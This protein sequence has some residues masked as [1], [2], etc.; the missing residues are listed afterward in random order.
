MDQITTL[1]IQLETIA[2]VV[3]CEVERI[4][5]TL[6]CLVCHSLELFKIT[7][8]D[9]AAV[10]RWLGEE[11][12]AL[13]EDGFYLS[14]PRLAAHRRGT[15]EKTAVSYSWP[16]ERMRDPDA[17]YRMYCHRNMGPMLMGLFERIKGVAWIYY[18]DVTNTA[19]QYPYIDQITAITPD[20]QWSGYHTYLSVEPGANPERGI[21]WT[22]PTMDYAGKGLILSASAPVYADDA[23]VGLWSLDVSVD[24]IIRPNL[25]A[26]SWG[27]QL[28]C[29]ADNRG[30]ALACNK[31]LGPCDATVGDEVLLPLALLHPGFASLDMEELYR[32]G[33]GNRFLSLECGNYLFLWEVVGAMDWICLSVLDKDELLSSAHERFRRAFSSL[34][35]GNG[36]AVIDLEH[37][38]PELADVGDAYNLMVHDLE[39]ARNRLLAQQ[40]DLARAKAAA[41]DAN[42]TK[43]EFIA[44]M[45]HEIRTPLNGIIGMLQLLQMSPLDPEQQEFADNAILASKRLTRLLSDILDIAAV[46]AGKLSLSLGRVRLRDV[47]RATEIL[48]GLYARE[49]GV[50]LR[51]TLDPRLPESIWGDETRLQQILLNLVGNGLKFT[52]AGS[53]AVEIGAL[54]SRESPC[55]GLLIAVADTGPGIADEQLKTAFDLFGQVSRGYTRTHQGAG[56]GLSIVKRLVDLMNGTLCVDSTVGLGTTVYVSLPVVAPPGKAAAAG[57]EHGATGPVGWAM[58]PAGGGNHLRILLVEDEP[59]NAFVMAQMLMKR[60]FDVTTAEDG[61]QAIAVLKRQCV[62]AILMDVQMPVVDG[63]EATRR[64]REGKAGDVNRSI[65]IIAMTAYA[66][67][68]DKERFLRCGMDDYIAKPVDLMHLEALLKRNIAKQDVP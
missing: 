12:F 36:N 16:P 55:A 7:P 18:Q 46:E 20:F 68:G 60:G 59:S 41:E 38:P 32:A 37:L 31:S 2:Q 25:F 21:R 54:A 5:D 49:K 66:M 57:A 17:R 56:L 28:T 14:L 50:A 15:L 62:D 33:S 24:S 6:T 44:N 4:R 47:L 8:K 39:Q 19:L 63:I 51:F 61:A 13:G 58:P 30:M 11:G 48:L 43:S 52:T 1:S 34:S 29:L 3:S 64:I 53:V 45:S 35:R 26:R 40:E 65:P 10:E 27:N 22:D 9:A 23:F 42:Q 67:S